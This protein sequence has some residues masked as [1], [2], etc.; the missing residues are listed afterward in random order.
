M[1]VATKIEIIKQITID[2]K[3]L[4]ELDPLQVREVFNNILINAIQSFKNNKGIIKLTILQ[5]ENQIKIIIEDNGTGIKKD[6]LDKVFDPFFTR[7][8]KGTGLGLSICNEIL[9]LHNGTIDLKS[10]PED[11]TTVEIMIPIEILAL[12]CRDECP[13]LR[14]AG[15][16]ML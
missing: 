6:D 9:N 10:T 15:D 12:L 2:K 14:N 1:V 16:Y 13:S 5:V 11:G 8:S 4:V 3:M 7:K